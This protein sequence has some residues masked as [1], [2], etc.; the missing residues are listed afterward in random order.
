MISNR[1][2]EEIR[3]VA[4]ERASVRSEVL[5]AI[6]S[7][8]TAR[9][10]K[11]ATLLHESMTK[12]A[13][14]KRKVQAPLISI[15]ESDHK[16]L[17]ALKELNEMRRA[18]P[19]L[20]SAPHSGPSHLHFA[21]TI[22]N[23][24]DFTLVTPPFDFEFTDRLGNEDGTKYADKLS[25]DFG[26]NVSTR[27][28]WT[29]PSA[30]I[31]FVISTTQLARVEIVP[32]AEFDYGWYIVA[33]FVT[34]HTNGLIGTLIYDIDDN[35]AVSIANDSRAVLWNEGVGWL[36]SNGAADHGYFQWRISPMGLTMVPGH[37]YLIWTWC[38][39]HCDGNFADARLNSQ[40][41][42]VTIRPI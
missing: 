14:L 4:I 34:S 27:G 19:K 7:D 17:M 6:K 26:F 18:S 31:G 39:G 8:L 33:S 38:E 3:N 13:E 40:L 35:G 20:L 16:A 28:D 9:W 5:D 21:D 30:G 36:D 1:T 15:I 10:V 25:G 24:G 22:I 23:P 42:W 41:H 11:R 2:G 32:F 37:R 12:E 29:S